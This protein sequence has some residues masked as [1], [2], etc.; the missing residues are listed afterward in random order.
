[1]ATDK[2]TK[3]TEAGKP[4]LDAMSIEERVNW[5]YIH[6]TGSIQDI[7][8]TH[9]MSVDE[10]LHII[11]QDELTTVY[12][13]GDLIDSSEAGPGAQLNGGQQHYVQYTTD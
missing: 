12:T 11:G 13:Q 8:R 1:M 5:F 3:D 2:Q 7:A 4:D 10:V 9:R 6:G